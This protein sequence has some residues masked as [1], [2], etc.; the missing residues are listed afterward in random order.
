MTPMQAIENFLLETIGLDS[1]SLGNNTVQRTVVQRMRVSGTQNLDEYLKKLKRDPSELQSLIDAVT[2]PETWFFRDKEPFLM[3]GNVIRRKWFPP[4]N[5]KPL[6]ILSLPGAAGGGP[7]AGAGG[8][9][10]GGGAAD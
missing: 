7:G 1:E 2:V 3:L 4:S 8:R 6:R 9:G 5:V 10:G